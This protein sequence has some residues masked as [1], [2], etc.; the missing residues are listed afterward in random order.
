MVW[1]FFCFSCGKKGNYVGD[2]KVNTP[3]NLKKAGRFKFA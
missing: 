3:S 2:C 1:E